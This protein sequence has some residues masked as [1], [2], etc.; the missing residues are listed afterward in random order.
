VGIFIYRGLYFGMY[1]S[2][3][4]V[5]ITGALE[6]NFLA[7]FL[8]GW[9]ITIVA[10]LASYPIDTVRR[11]MMMTSGQAVKY[12][13]SM[14]AFGQ[15]IAKVRSDGCYQICIWGMRHMF[16]V[17]A[18]GRR[19]PV[20][21]CWRQHSARHRWCRCAVWLRPAAGAQSGGLEPRCGSKI[22]VIGCQCRCWCSARRTRLAEVKALAF[23]LL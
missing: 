7:S 15:I 17:S 9:S 6:G 12:K 14:D 19:L 22:H 21:G 10:G 23:W 1:D 4:P 18:G 5:L 3:K 8:L 2:L 13:S 11:R 20:Q 16:S